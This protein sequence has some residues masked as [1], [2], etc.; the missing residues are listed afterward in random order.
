[1]KLV[2]LKGYSDIVIQCHNNPDPDTI[3]A[4]YALYKFFESQGKKVRLIYGG[5]FKITKP[6]VRMIINE[7]KIPLEYVED[8]DIEELLITIDCQYG[9][10]NVAKFKA[11]EVAIIDHHLEE[12]TGIEKTEIRSFLSSASTLVWD[13]LRE[14]GFNVNE[15]IDVSTGLYYGLFTDSGGFA[16]MA[17]P[18]D[19]DMQE[20]LVVDNRIFRKLKNSVLTLSE[21]E[22]AGMALIRHSYNEANKFALVRAGECDPNILG[23]I[24]DLALQVDSVLVCVVY[25]ESSLG[26]KFSV[27]SCEN[28]IMA[29]ELAAFL[30]EDIGSGGGHRDKAG[31]FISKSDYNKT[32]A[33]LNA[34]EYFLRRLTKYYKSFDV[35]Y[36]KTDRVSMEGMKLYKNRALIVGFVPLAEVVADQTPIIIRTLEGDLD[37]LSSKDIYIMIG[38]KGE[39]YPITQE[40]FEKNYCVLDGNYNK[41]FEYF[42]SIRNK[43][44]SNVIHLQ[45]IA[46]KCIS[47]GESYIYAKP[48]KKATKVFTAWDGEK[49]MYG[50][51]NDYLAVRKDDE[52]EIYIIEQ[53]VFRKTYDGQVIFKK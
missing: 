7:F 40:N 42:P 14:E 34:D 41:E 2:D 48:L 45:S 21:L 49:Y 38:I 32:C 9:A 52:Q 28:E 31:G 16:E 27:R 33:H 29:N 6:N 19:K 25:S 35:I 44:D 17:H 51:I 47:K 26:I 5:T 53:D 50:K 8:I 13:L 18:L 36:S 11:K 39:V 24:S 4:G 1:M 23:F 22:I 12:V 37:L 20:S 30:A 10:G 15:H 3:G 43:Q 46:K